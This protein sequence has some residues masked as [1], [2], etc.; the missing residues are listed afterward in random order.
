[1]TAT[2]LTTIREFVEAL[3]THAATALNGVSCRGV[4]QLC[5]KFPDER[6]M[7]TSAFNIGDV[8]RMVEAAVTDAEAGKNVYAE[9]RTVTPGL[10]GERGQARAT[11]GVFALVVDRDGDK[12]KAGCAG[13][14]ASLTV[15]TSPDNTHEWF[16]FERALNPDAAKAIGDTIREASGAD[17]CTGVITQPFRVA[18]TPN[19]PDA[20]KIAR[21]RV[22]SP[23]RV[24]D[25]SGRLW[26]PDELVAAFTKPRPR[27]STLVEM[28]VSRRATP[29]MDRSAQ[30]QSA[31]AAAVA[32]NMTPDDLETLMRQ[33]PDGCAQKYLEAGDRLRA[34][35]RR[36]WAKAAPDGGV[37]N[38]S[39]SNTRLA[40]WRSANPDRY[41]EYMRD[42]MR[43][44]RS[45]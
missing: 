28:K 45:T 35:I 25:V 6:R 44:R 33:H 4:V 11:L 38:S 39:V 24:I 27:K 15:E 7:C 3:H 31:I 18:G 41:R 1:M 29:A 32:A 26:T 5:S 43:R 2:D 22:V 16:F 42:Y 34:E 20:K 23:T 19:Y 36:S 37:S 8:D 13:A 14:H 9:A 40:R 21:G 17:S 12:G 30:F 10:R